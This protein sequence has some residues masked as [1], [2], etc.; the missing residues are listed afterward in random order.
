[1]NRRT[2]VIAGAASLAATF[3]AVGPAIAQSRG[4]A[5]GAADQPGAAEQKHMQD[6]MRVGSLSLITS[7]LAVQKAQNA[8]L[9][10]FAQFEVAEQETIAEVLKSMQGANITTGQGAAPNAELQGHLDDKGKATLQKLQSASGDAFD[11][12]YW[13]GQ[14]DGHQELLQIQ[15]TYIRSGRQREAVNVAKLA[16]GQIKEHLTLLDNISGQM[17]KG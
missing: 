5:P 1:M 13:Q 16:R 11:R 9:K 14:K 7:R 10:Q 6:T 12:E 3:P 15:E 4:P 17:K 8:Q 2:L